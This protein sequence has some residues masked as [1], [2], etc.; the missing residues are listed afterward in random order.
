ML[1]QLD[2]DEYLQYM[3]KFLRDEVLK[4][5]SVEKEAYFRFS[6]LAAEEYLSP[7]PD[8]VSYIEHEHLERLE[9][10]LHERTNRITS[11]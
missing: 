8:G 6:G 3:D 2:T 4:L 7:I 9:S 1:R 5:S 11:E 10:Q